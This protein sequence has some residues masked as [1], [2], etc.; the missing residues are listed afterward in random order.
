MKAL[1]VDDHPLFRAALVHLIE[2][3]YPNSV[4]AQTG[5]A[6]AGLKILAS[7]FAGDAFDVVLLDLNLP[8][9]SGAIAVQAMVSAAKQT[10]VIVVSASERVREV[11]LVLA[12][13]A[14]SYLLKSLPPETFLNA[15]NLALAGDVQHLNWLYSSA[16]VSRANVPATFA[17]PPRGGN[18]DPATNLRGRLSD[19][20]FTVL[21][22]L[23]RGCTNREISE[24]L[25]ITEAT[26]KTHLS[27]VFRVLSVVTRSQAIFAAREVGF[28]VM[29]QE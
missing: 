17:I 18:I 23:C 29:E 16:T 10:P 22:L 20:Q 11:K 6:E 28:E 7:K 12:L 1:I 24:Q 2:K 8:G 19:R 27:I 21:L 25:K 4:I 9:M 5:T 13:G 14:K 15:L 26:V 3:T